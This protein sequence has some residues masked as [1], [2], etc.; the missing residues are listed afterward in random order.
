MSVMQGH[1]AKRPD[2][3]LIDRNHIF[4][5]QILRLEFLFFFCFKNDI[6]LNIFFL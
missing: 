2:G 5:M 3:A 6:V 4:C 1:L